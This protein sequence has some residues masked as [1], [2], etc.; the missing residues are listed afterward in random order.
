MAMLFS[1]NPQKQSN[2][3]YLHCFDQYLIKPLNRE[4]TTLKK[5]NGAWAMLCSSEIYAP[6]P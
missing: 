4:F 2:V 6:V 1:I 5:H 3:Q